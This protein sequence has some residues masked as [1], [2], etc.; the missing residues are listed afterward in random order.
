MGFLSDV[1]FALR[2][3]FRAPTFSLTL[4]GV[5]IA[6]IGATTA[7][8]SIA[9]SLLLRPLAYPRPDEL[10]MVWKT[11][12]PLAKEWPTSLPDFED[13]HRDNQTFSQLAATASHPF[14][15]S[16]PDGRAAEFFVGADVTGDFFALFELKPLQGRLLGPDD[17]RRDAPRVCVI[18]AAVWRKRFGAD[19]NLVGS[20]IQ[21]NA[22]PFTVVGIA[23]EGFRF[24]APRGGLADVWVSLQRDF[25]GREDQITRDSNFMRVIGRRKPG[26]TLEQ[27]QADMSNVAHGLEVKYPETNAHRGVYLVDLHEALVGRAR[28]N[29]LVLFGAVALLF[30]VVCANVAS[31]LL[32]R[33][34]TRRGEMAARAAL[35]ATRGRLVAQL[36]TESAVIFAIGGLGGALVASFL[37]DFFA[38]AVANQVQAANIPLRIDV[39]AFVFALASALVCGI[40]FGLVPALSTSRVEPYAVLKETSAAAGVNRAQRM[41]RGG[42]VV[43]QVAVAFALLVASGVALRSLSR[44]VETPPGFDPEG[45]AIANLALPD[46]TYREPQQQADFFDHLL[47]K[48]SAL[49]GVESAAACSALPMGGT[50]SNGWFKIEGRTPWAPNEG[51]I[52]ENNVVSAGYFHTMKVPV[53]RGREFNANDDKNGRP[54]LIISQ[55]AATK[56]FPNEDAIGHRIDLDDGSGWREIIGVVGDV[57]K[58]D[59]LHPVLPEG[60]IPLKE[61]P[62]R[63]MSIVVRSSRPEGSLD[64]VRAITKGMD[65]ALAVFGTRLYRDVVANTMQGQRFLALLL[66]AFALAGLV[67][68]TMGLFGLVSYS[69]SQRTRELGLRMALGSSPGAVVAL[70]VRGGAKLVGM[71]LAIG[72]V[73]AAILSKQISEH[74]AGDGRVDPLL[75]LTI[76]I[77]LGVAGLASCALPAWRAARIPPSSALRYE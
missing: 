36:V 30:L 21:L 10:T 60:F 4:L 77:V 5:L 32:A 43:A 16:T 1:R 40:A 23:P 45:A 14:S 58:Y 42:L 63:W 33:G 48:L 50:N 13:L 29:V 6:G 20:T 31:L 8:F 52:L 3:L 61:S 39:G 34:A 64:E 75:F 15:L 28:E 41:T 9:E 56:F 38:E 26:V 67:L 76:P 22:L 53:L 7:M 71:G 17:D 74:I 18:S 59:L 72:L 24:M 49:P 19:P 57:R 68:S 11:H 62:E 46:A 65:P 55:E 35:G 37:V 69:T 27:A 54:V 51:P 44:I 25:E 73:G 2:L 66:A 70:V 47:T 12:E